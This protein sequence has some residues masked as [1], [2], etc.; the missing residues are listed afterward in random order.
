MHN[1]SVS[2]FFEQVPF[3]FKQIH[4][5]KAISW[6]WPRMLGNLSIHFVIHFLSISQDIYAPLHPH[7]DIVYGSLTKGRRNGGI[8][9]TCCFVLARC[10]GVFEGDVQ[11][12]AQL[13]IMLI[14]YLVSLIYEGPIWE[15][16]MDKKVEGS[17]PQSEKW[18][19]WPHWPL[20]LSPLGLTLILRGG[21]LH[22]RDD[23]LSHKNVKES[24]P[25]HIGN[26]WSILCAYV[27]LEVSR[28]GG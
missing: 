22:P 26:C 16:R 8:V 17:C 11:F 9:P 4:Q 1:R 27:G 13:L 23:P 21:D 25:R 12:G 10:R 7:A 14:L 2:T 5:Y 19:P 6:T 24:D 20:L 3:Y 28:Y 15:N 18:G